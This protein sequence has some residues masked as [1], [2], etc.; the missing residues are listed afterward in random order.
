MN[1]LIE[2]IKGRKSIRTYDG[3][4]LSD[5]HRQDIEAF[6]KDIPNPFGIPVE[7]V[8]LDA[9]EHALSSPVL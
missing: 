1:N 9:K 6:M 3:N 2:I 4:A 7:F 5:A 8:L